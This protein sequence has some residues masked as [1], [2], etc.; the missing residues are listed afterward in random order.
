M[1]HYK[2]AKK[3]YLGIDNIHV[4]RDSLNKVVEALREAF[5]AGKELLLGDLPR[6]GQAVEGEEEVGEGGEGFGGEG[7]GGEDRLSRGLR[8]QGPPSGTSART[9]RRA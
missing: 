2:E 5:Q 9:A 8:C 7:L 1:D 3:A 6:L 4:M